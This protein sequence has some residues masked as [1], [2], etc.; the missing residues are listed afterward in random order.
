MKFGIN[1]PNFG[2][3]MTPNGMKTWAQEAESLGFDSLLLS[4]HIAL[5]KDAHQRSP[6]PFY[7]CVSSLAWLAAHTEKIQLGTGVLIGTHRHPIHIARVTS[8][9]DQLC[10]GRLIVGVGVGWAPRAFD[11]L[12]IPFERRGRLTDELLGTLVDCWTNSSVKYSGSV[13]VH[14]VFTEPLPVRKPHPPLWIGGNGAPALRRVN[15]HQA[16]WHPLHP[17]RSLAS[18]GTSELGSG[19]GFAPRIFFF[20]TELAVADLRRPLGVGNIRQIRED[21]EFLSDLGAETIVLDTDP[22][23]QRLRRG[24]EEDLKV[25]RMAS[26]VLG[27]EADSSETI[28]REP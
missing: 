9:I 11:V 28:A 25:L 5:T 7:E 8:T 20:P 23:D 12:G 1:L 14:S 13:G 3:Q 15:E 10:G 21:V 27:I 22:G 4:D 26:D 19:T 16:T 6:A 2:P 18:N 17:T 24:W